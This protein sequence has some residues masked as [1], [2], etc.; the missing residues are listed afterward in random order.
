MYP[1]TNLPQAWSCTARLKIV[2]PLAHK[3]IPTVPGC[4]EAG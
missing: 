2:R 3:A 4:H 1:K